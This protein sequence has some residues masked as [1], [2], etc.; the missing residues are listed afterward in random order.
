MVSV[1]EDVV[2]AWL[3]EQLENGKISEKEALHIYDCK[4]YDE[5]LMKLHQ[6]VNKTNDST[7][8]EILTG[9][10]GYADSKKD[11]NCRRS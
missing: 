1:K 4:T 6:L 11:I 8:L 10:C 7:P 9:K 2:Y 5:W 3:L